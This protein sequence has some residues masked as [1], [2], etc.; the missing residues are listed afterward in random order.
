MPMD[1]RDATYALP[2]PKTAEKQYTTTTQQRL[3]SRVE[4]RVKKHEE[5]KKNSHSLNHM[6]FLQKFSFFRP[7][8]YYFHLLQ[9]EV[10]R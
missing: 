8:L 3:D 7:S 6:Q 4:L 5:R 1:G 9:R 2:W 10:G